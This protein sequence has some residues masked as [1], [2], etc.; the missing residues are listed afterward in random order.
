MGRL[1]A[2]KTDVRFGKHRRSPGD[3]YRFVGEAKKEA[4]S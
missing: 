3:R 4:A 1:R 2:M